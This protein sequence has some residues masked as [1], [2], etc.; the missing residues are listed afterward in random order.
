MI[1]KERIAMDGVEADRIIE[2]IKREMEKILA[3]R[4]S[5]AGVCDFMDSFF[6]RRNSQSS[7]RCNRIIASN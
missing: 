1:F 2:D 6:D 4:E 5:R 7:F 3:R